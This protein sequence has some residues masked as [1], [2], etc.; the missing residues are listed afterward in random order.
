M[1]TPISKAFLSVYIVFKKAAQVN[2][3]FATIRDFKFF[4]QRRLFR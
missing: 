1:G 4:H 3:Y 2:I